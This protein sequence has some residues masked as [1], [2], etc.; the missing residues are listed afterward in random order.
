MSCWV[1][2]QLAF[3][4]AISASVNPSLSRIAISS[5]NAASTFAAFSGAEI[6]FATNNALSSPGAA[7]TD[8]PADAV[9]PCD[10]PTDERIRLLEVGVV[11]D[12]RGG[13]AVA[14]EAHALGEREAADAASLDGAHRD[15]TVRNAVFPFVGGS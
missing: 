5:R 15:S 9:P 10:H 4:A 11:A 2:S 7:A 6:A 13:A 14:A 3:P 8:E 12:A 1:W